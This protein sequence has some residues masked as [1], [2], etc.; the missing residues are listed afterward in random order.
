M[1]FKFGHQWQMNRWAAEIALLK[2]ENAVR[3]QARSNVAPPEE[4]LDPLL[5]HRTDEMA[6]EPPGRIPPLRIPAVPISGRPEPRPLLVPDP[7]DGRTR[8]WKIVARSR[9][10]GS[11]F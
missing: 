2:A 8:P 11:T 10:C 3:R 7:P 1:A 6:G 5:L 9:W 4:P